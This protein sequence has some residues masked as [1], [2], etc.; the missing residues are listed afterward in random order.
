DRSGDVLRH[1]NL[2]GA[3]PHGGVLVLAGD[4]PAA[5]SSTVP[6]ATERT[7]ASL[8]MPVLFPRNS[9]ELITFGLY[10]IELSRAS[11]CWTALKIVADVAD[12]LWTVD[13][14]FTELPITRP[15]VEWDGRPWTYRQQILQVPSH[16]LRAEADLVGPR[17]AM[18]R[19]FGEAN[20]IDGIEVD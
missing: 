18:V 6:C 2:Y 8:D 3:D 14:D 9:A 5:K 10:G 13:E 16:S 11:G 17:W 4:D 12:G 20:P 7:L 1:G 15:V 19:A